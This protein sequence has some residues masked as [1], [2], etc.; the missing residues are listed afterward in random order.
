MRRVRTRLS[1][2]WL[3][4]LSA[5]GAVHGGPPLDVAQE[6]ERLKAQYGF[7]I[8]DAHLEITRESKGRAEGA[9]LLG[10][11]NALL[12]GFDYVIVQGTKGVER[13]LIL[14]SKAGYGGPPGGTGAVAPPADQAPAEPASGAEIVLESQRK[15]TSHALTLALEGDNGQKVQRVLLLDT[16]ADF[17]VLPL[18]LIAQLGIQPAALRTQRVQTANGAV[19]AKLGTLAGVWLGGQRVPGVEAAFIEDSKLGGSALL[20]MSVLGRFRVT[21]DDAQN[22]VV[23]SGK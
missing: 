23:L 12:D 14:G 1:I 19:D 17:V 4:T 18:S 13:V 8:D 10:R 16:G 5:A 3:L 9:D 2:V 22:R 21:I 11:L 15:G 20:G 7:Q 6:L